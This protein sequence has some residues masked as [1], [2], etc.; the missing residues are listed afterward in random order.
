[1]EEDKIKKEV[2]RRLEVIRAK[3][4]AMWEKQTDSERIDDIDWIK[5]PIVAGDVYA[6]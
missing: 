6:G 1:M 4:D 5:A 2:L 3:A